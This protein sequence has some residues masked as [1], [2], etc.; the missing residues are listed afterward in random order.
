[1]SLWSRCQ[2]STAWRFKAR[3]AATLSNGGTLVFRARNQVSNAND[4]TVTELDRETGKPRVTLAIGRSAA[5][6]P[7]RRRSLL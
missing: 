5:R 7:K 2:D 3:R 4:G 6:Q 1:M